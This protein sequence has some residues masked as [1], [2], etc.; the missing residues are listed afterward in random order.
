MKKPTIKEKVQAFWLTMDWLSKGGTMPQAVQCS[1][2]GR[3]IMGYD[4]DENGNPICRS[5]ALEREPEREEK[6]DADDKE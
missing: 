3:R 4:L 2:C 1:R 6:D 5:H